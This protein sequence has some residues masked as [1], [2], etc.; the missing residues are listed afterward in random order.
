MAATVV[1]YLHTCHHTQR[2]FGI[3]SSGGQ[4]ES[5][6]RIMATLHSRVRQQVT[7]NQSGQLYRWL[8]SCEEYLQC[9]CAVFL[10][11]VMTNVPMASKDIWQWTLEELA[12]FYAL[13]ALRV[14]PT[15]GAWLKCW[16]TT[17]TTFELNPSISKRLRLILLEGGYHPDKLT[18]ELQKVYP[19]IMTKIGFEL[20]PKPTIAEKTA[21]GKSGF[22]PVATRWG[23][24]TVER[25]DGTM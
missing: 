25:L 2:Y 3:T 15:I 17:W 23:K 24:R 10:D 1:I 21:Q 11:F 4:K 12:V 5:S 19:Q 8:A 9:K 20:A 18:A 13:Y 7:K 6:E 16:A 14:C 22:V